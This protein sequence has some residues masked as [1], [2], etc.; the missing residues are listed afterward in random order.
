MN[1]DILTLAWQDSSGCVVRS[2]A[3]SE[4]PYHF[5][6]EGKIQ[7]LLVAVPRWLPEGILNNLFS[8]YCVAKKLVKGASVHPRQMRRWLSENGFEAEIEATAEVC[9]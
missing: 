4:F 6:G 7:K 9:R 2:V 1:K 8:A 3:E 5:Q